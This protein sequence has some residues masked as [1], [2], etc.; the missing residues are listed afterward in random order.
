MGR[1]VVLTGMIKDIVRK[2]KKKKKSSSGHDGL[3][4][5]D[6]EL[7]TGLLFEHLALLF[8]TLFFSGVVP[9][10]LCIGVIAPI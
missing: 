3:C 9:D 2:L 4:A 5:W 8:Q 1:V 6:L 10:N 7:G